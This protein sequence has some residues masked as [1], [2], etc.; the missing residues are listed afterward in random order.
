MAGG[1]FEGVREM[2][3]YRTLIWNLANAVVFGM[4]AAKMSY[5]IPDEWTPWWLIIYIVG[6][7]LLRFYTTGPVGNKQ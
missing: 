5:S 6:N 4:E 7:V 2:K 1:V 3:G